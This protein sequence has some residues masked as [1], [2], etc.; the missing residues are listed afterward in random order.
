MISLW[1]GWWF[2]RGSP[3]GVYGFPD[4]IR[5]VM[6]NPVRVFLKTGCLF[7]N[8]TYDREAQSRFR[9]PIE[10]LF[11]LRA[12]HL[13]ELRLPVSGGDGE[14]GGRDCLLLKFHHL[15][16][17]LAVLPVYLLHDPALHHQLRVP[18][19]VL[20]V[21]FGSAPGRGHALLH[22]PAHIEG[23]LYEVPYLLGY[24]HVVC[25]PDVPVGPPVGRHAPE[26]RFVR[27][28]E[29]CAPLSLYR[30]VR[31]PLFALRAHHLLHHRAL[32]RRHTG[33]HLGHQ[34][35]HGLA[36]LFE[37]DLGVALLFVVYHRYRALLCVYDSPG[38][39]ILGHVLQLCA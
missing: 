30:Y 11:H 39:P 26:G 23:L 37:V 17:D 28:Y 18:G 19:R 31:D 29:F 27:R 33:H 36:E 9:A 21:G 22:L 2:R 6:R 16:F 15:S 20:G 13:E 35:T 3:T 10:W 4:V 25:Y 38:G 14:L 8:F 24:G 1:Q 5:T 34:R 12:H 32:F 7:D